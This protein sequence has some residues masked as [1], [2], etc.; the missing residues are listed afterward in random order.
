MGY[1]KYRRSF[2][3]KLCSCKYLPEKKNRPSSRQFHTVEPRYV[4]SS[5][6]RIPRKLETKLISLGFASKP[7]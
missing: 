2:T 1:E 7:R 5:V 6:T 3:L 4:E